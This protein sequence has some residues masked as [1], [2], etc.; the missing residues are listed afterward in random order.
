MESSEFISDRRWT[1]LVL[2]AFLLVCGAMLMAVRISAHGW[3]IGAAGLFVLFLILQTQVVYGFTLA[4]TGWWLLR[5]GGDPVRIN[6]TLPPNFVAGKL[7]PTA[8]IMPIFNEDVG[9]VF[10]GLRAM[11]QSLAA[12]GKSEAF[13]LFI[14]SDSADLNVWIEEE[15]A[16]FDLCKQVGGFGHIFYRKRRL[17]LHHKSGNVADFCRRWGSRYRFL[18]VLDADSVMAGDTLVRL[19]GLMEKHPQVG[20]IQTYSRAVL[21]RSLCQRITQFASYAYGPLFVAGA[22][23]WQLDNASFYGHNAIIRVEPFMRYCAMPELPPSGKLG[24]RIMSHDTVEAALIRRAGYEVWSDYDLGG[25]YEE[26]PPHL[27]ASLQRDRRWCHGNMQHS[28]FLFSRGLTMPSRVNILIGI[29]AYLSSPLWL[30]FL[31]FSPI[32]FIGERIAAQN[33]FLFVCSMSLLFIPKLLAA[34]RMISI[35]EVRI[36]AGGG[37]KIMLSILGETVYSMILAPILMLFYTQF[38]WSS[39]FGGSAGWARQKR[40]D[41]EGPSWREC[42]IVHS[43]HTVLAVAACGLVAWFLPAMLPWLLLVLVGPIVS[44]PFSRLVASNK[45]GELARRR[46]WFLIPEETNLPPELQPLEEPVE[47]SAAAGDVSREF[48]EDF[49]LART[50]L[51]PRLNALHVS[52]LRERPHASLDAHERVTAL[53]DR[54]LQNGPGA[55]QPRE[56]K[57]LLWDADAMLA[58]HQK[59]WASPSVCWHE[60]WQVAFKT[61]LKSIPQSI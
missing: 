57:I 40:A 13:D 2:N 43:T 51:D 58:L 29:M 9:R 50:I 33:S 36:L 4:V 52:I 31:L 26:G 35:H 18:I 48:A 5:R 19:V 53:C 59:L 21:G 17:T 8:I 7:P 16:W 42:L 22:N 14:L 56:K 1:F 23:F 27:P 32:L 49:G 39:F 41:E 12:T 38:V 20:I 10:R 61:Y 60:W 3:T 45:L 28:W 6:Q 46:G 15:K 24:T 54:L 11:F 44:I 55:L 25:S 47:P 37:L 30:L 34:Q